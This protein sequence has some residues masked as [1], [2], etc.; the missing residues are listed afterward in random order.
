MDKHTPGPW[1]AFSVTG[2]GWS[3]RREHERPGY[4]GLAPICT[5]AWWQFDIP[6]IIDDKIS[7]ANA[8]VIAAAPDLLH[9]LEVLYEEADN[10]SVQGVSFSERCMGHKGPALAQAAIAKARGQ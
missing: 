2:A 6:G 3:V 10:F 9:A 7:E 8:R 1:E 4:T 5:L